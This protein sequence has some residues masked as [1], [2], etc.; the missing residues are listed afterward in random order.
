MGAYGGIKRR[1]LRTWSYSPDDNIARCGNS[2]EET[3]KAPHFIL[4]YPLLKGK[5]RC[6]NGGRRDK[7]VSF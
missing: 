4:R 7:H 6:L 5:K 3:A 1:D 2:A